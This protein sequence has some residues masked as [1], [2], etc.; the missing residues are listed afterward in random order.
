MVV[1]NNVFVEKVCAL[2]CKMRYVGCA[3]NNVETE[4]A[5]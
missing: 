4:T 5:F 1:F 2:L 3:C